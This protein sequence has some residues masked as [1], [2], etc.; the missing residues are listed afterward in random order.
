MLFQTE[1]PLKME[2][3][4]ARQTFSE[5]SLLNS[6]GYQARLQLV[7][8]SDS[9]Y[10]PIYD[11]LSMP[12]PLQRKAKKRKFYKV[13]EEG[14]TGGEGSLPEESNKAALLLTQNKRYSSYHRQHLKNVLCNENGLFTVHFVTHVTSQW[15]VVLR[16]NKIVN[17]ITAGS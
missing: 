4:K 3:R 10:N 7:F 13:N 12:P 6:V 17:C 11:T 8:C 16:S 9:T 15:G 14:H 5:D 2:M 1:M